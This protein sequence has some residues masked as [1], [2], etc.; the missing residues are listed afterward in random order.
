MPRNEMD[1]SL[2]KGIYFNK[3]FSQ[4]SLSKN[5]EHTH[6]SPTTTYG[7]VMPSASVVATFPYLGKAWLFRFFRLGNFALLL[8]FLSGRRG[9]APYGTIPNRLRRSTFTQGSLSFV[10]A[11]PIKNSRFVGLFPVFSLT[12]VPLSV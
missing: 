2:F 4:E 10:L 6:P 1:F 11:K 12:T 9:A 3:N 5:K 8:R 7:C